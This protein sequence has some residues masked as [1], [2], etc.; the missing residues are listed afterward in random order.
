MKTALEVVLEAQIVRTH[1]LSEGRLHHLA[2]RVGEL[3]V[4]FA[5]QVAGVT[6]FAS[7]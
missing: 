1:A 2:G 7:P 5:G 3:L 4:A 6:L